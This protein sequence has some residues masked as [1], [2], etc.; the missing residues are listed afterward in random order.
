MCF[1][2]EKGTLDRIDKV[3]LVLPLLPAVDLSSTLFALNFGGEEIGILARPILQS[4][5]AY[6]LLML[7][8]SASLMFLVFMQTVIHIRRLLIKE[9][10]LKWTR[11][12]LTIPIYWIFLLEAVYV[13]TVIL[14]LLVPLS[15]PQTETIIL[16]V[17]L[18]GTFFA[19][20]STL[21]QPQM[22]QLPNF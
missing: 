19:C 10:K 3:L 16:K 12:F 21:T 2:G 17:L 14:N 4:F 6:G 1:L 20:I 18:T 5:G 9:M 13:S 15:F 22:R 8:T 11:H 7:A